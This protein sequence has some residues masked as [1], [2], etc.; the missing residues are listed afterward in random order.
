[1]PLK[2][3]VKFGLKSEILLLIKQSTGRWIRVLKL[4]LEKYFG[5]QLVIHFANFQL[6]FFSDISS[7]E[8]P[9]LIN[10]L[11]TK[12]ESMTMVYSSVPAGFSTIIV[13]LNATEPNKFEVC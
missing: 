2:R 8:D 10:G 6:N 12:G 13:S 1:M 7:L 9:A 11:L 3:I 4:S 5:H